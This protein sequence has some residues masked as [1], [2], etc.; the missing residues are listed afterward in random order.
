MTKFFVL[1]EGSSLQ[2]KSR[3]ACF[4][5]LSALKLDVLGN[6][7]RTGLLCQIATSYVNIPSQFL[8]RLLAPPELNLIGD[9]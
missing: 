6:K 4:L 9:V 8:Q 7:S 2:W 5:N 3:V 1:A